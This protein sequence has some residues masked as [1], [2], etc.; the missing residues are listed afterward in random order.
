MCDIRAAAMQSGEDAHAVTGARLHSVRST[1]GCGPPCLAR[2]HRR[3][4]HRQSGAT[5]GRALRPGNARR[6]AATY[7][8]PHVDGRG[9]GSSRCRAG[10]PATCTSTRM[11]SA[12]FTAAI[13]V[14]VRQQ[15]DKLLAAEAGD[16]VIALASQAPVAA[17][18]Q[19]A[20]GRGRRTDARALSFSR[21]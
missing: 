9:N 13:R 15:N 7:G 8:R 5:D 11:R 10:D 12:T 2:V 20:A 17:T 1:R 21:F 18:R 4:P 6:H 14:G 19:H 16:E 3:S